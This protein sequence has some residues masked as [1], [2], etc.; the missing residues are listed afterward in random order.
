MVNFTSSFVFVFGLVAFASS[1]CDF[2]S[3]FC[4][5]SGITCP[6]VSITFQ[7]G[8]NNY[9]GAN[10]DV[11]SF[12]D[13]TLNHGDIQG[14]VATRNNFNGVNGVSVGD[15]LHD[16]L[17]YSLIVG[18]DLILDG[19]GAV[20]P[21]NHSIFVGGSASVPSDIDLASR[22]VN[23]PNSGC[24]D[25]YFNAAL[26]YWTQ[27]SL[28]LSNQA[29]N[30]DVSYTD[31]IAM[32]TC[33]SLSISLRR[34]DDDDD[35]SDNGSSDSTSSGAYFITMTNVDFNNIIGYSTTNCS[36]SGSWV[37]NINGANDVIFGGNSI[38]VSGIVIFNVISSARVIVN[39]SVNGNLVAPSSDVYM[40]GGTIYGQVIAGNLSNVIQIN[41]LTDCPTSSS[42]SSGSNSSSGSASSTG[43]IG[44]PTAVNGEAGNA[45]NDGANFATVV[46]V[47]FAT[48]A[49]A[50]ALI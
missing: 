7:D 45:Q 30:V 31:G 11:I 10:I 16:N 40:S 35:S 21:L 5:I 38:Q 8:S 17:Q 20:Y 9:G 19:A 29:D 42:S 36:S 32:L 4:G 13:I 49:I 14:R 26:S 28:S 48:L 34:S 25:S 18:Q 46:S 37:F 3:N 47:A 43:S 39:S 12:N 15:Q 44:Q 22:I 1:T 6:N 24:L 33:R 41:Q 23:C 50:L 2:S 27:F